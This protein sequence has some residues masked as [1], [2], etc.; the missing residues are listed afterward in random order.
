[1]S[2]GTVYFVEA[3]GRGIKVGFSTNVASRMSQLQ[4]ASPTKLRVIATIDGGLAV[5]RRIH[6]LL[7]EHRL[8]GEW[9][10]DV[11]AVRDMI[12]LLKSEG[13]AAL[14]ELP[15]HKRDKLKPTSK[16]LAAKLAEMLR[17]YDEATLRKNLGWDKPGSRGR[18]NRLVRGVQEPGE[19]EVED[20]SF[21]YACFAVEKIEFDR[22]EHRRLSS[23]ITAFIGNIQ[24]HVFR[25]PTSRVESLI[26]RM[27]AATAERVIDSGVR[28]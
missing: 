11:P 18:L 2:E 26:A 12:A 21:A 19:G 7:K 22:K 13:L 6:A 5:E 27:E 15:V 16:V 3:P 10:E 28:Q 14:G 4:G 24:T 17:F 25:L 1:M 20:I 9:F 23:E 8:S